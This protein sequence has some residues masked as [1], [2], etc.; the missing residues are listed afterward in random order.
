[1]PRISA[2]P[3][4]IPSIRGNPIMRGTGGYSGA[5]NDRRA[6]AEWKVAYGGADQVSLPDLPTLRARS[7]DLL[8]NAP[9]AIG[10]AQ[11]TVANAIGPGLNVMPAIDREY[12]GLDQ[13]AADA[14]ERHAERVWLAWATDPDWC[15]VAGRL[16]FFAMQG[17]AEYSEFADGDCFALRRYVPRPG[18]VLALKLQLLEADR[19]SNPNFMPDTDRLAGGVETDDFGR[20]IAYHVL[21]RNP[22]DW[23]PRSQR[24]E[25]VPA[26]GA[27]TQDRLVLHQ[28]SH[29]R[30]GQTRGVPMLAP[31]IETLKQLDRYTEAELMAAVVG[32]MFTV[33]IKSPTGD[34]LGPMGPVVEDQGRGTPGTLTGEYRLGN[35]AIIDLMPGEEIQSADPKRPNQAFDPFIQAILRQVGAAL[36]IPFEILI[37]HFSSSY[38]ASRAALL[39]AWRAVATRRTRRVRQFCQPVYSWVIA[40]AV[41][42]GVIEAPGFFEDPLARLAWCRADWTGPTMGQLNPVDESTAAEKRVALGVSTLA[43]ET[44]QLTGGSWEQKHSQRVKEHEMRLRDGLEAPYTVAG[45]I[46]TGGGS[47]AVG[48]P[49]AAPDPANLGPGQD[50]QSPGDLG[51]GQDPAP[52]DGTAGNA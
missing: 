18:D 33:F 47:A 20:P 12:L 3:A 45:A 48:A 2:G 5:R 42:R 23:F 26:F 21:E 28:L 51:P 19:V 8:R 22:Y 16:D 43:E 24:W 30:I 34:G 25:A 37:K 40:E 4:G 15:D 52:A 13:E 46:P 9:I 36:E 49:P 1:M 17:V 14:W 27:G 44:A 35:G 10:A 39:E 41:A 32:A 50:P 11:T 31:V 29:R 6:L 7:Q 38:S